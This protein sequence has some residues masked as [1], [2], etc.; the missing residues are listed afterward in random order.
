MYRLGY[1][2]GYVQ[3][4]VRYDQIFILMIRKIDFF[5]VLYF[6]EKNMFL[7]VVF[8]AENDGSLDFGK[9]PDLVVKNWFLRVKSLKKA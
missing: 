8:S 1:L 3:T 4:Y 6:F 5:K 7:G 2:S 9:N